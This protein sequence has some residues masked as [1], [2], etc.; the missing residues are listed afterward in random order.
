MRKSTVG[1]V[2]ALASVAFTFGCT[3]GGFKSL[4]TTQVSG[5]VEDGNPKLKVVHKVADAT[6]WLIPA[7]DVAAM[8]K[9]PIEVKRDAKNDEPL[10]DNLAANRA[11]YLK[12]KTSAKGEFNFENVPGGNY[13][14]Y[15]EPATSTY[16][17]GGDKSRKAL[18]NVQLGAKPLTIKL[19]G[20]VPADA[21]YVGTT[22]CLECH[23]DQK[24]FINTQ[25]RL[26]IQVIG[27]PSLLQ[28]YSRFPDYNKGLDKLMAGTKFW[29]HGYDKTRGFDKYQI[30][31]K[32]P[33]DASSVSFTATFF[34]D[35]DG[36]LKFRSENV[37]DASDAPRLYPVELAYGGG[38]YKQRY[39]VRVGANLF[40]F[41]QFNQN[42]SDDFGDRARKPWRDYHADWFFNEETKKLANPPQ[43]K[44]FDKECASCHYNA[45][46][47][48]KTA[49]GDY[50]AGSSN[51]RNGELDID[52]DGKPNEINM[53]CET[54]HGPGSV[55]VAAPKIDMASTIVT[56]S[57]LSAER[58]AMICGQCHS[59]PQGHLKNDQP[60]NAANKM[61]LPGTSRNV[62]LKEYTTREDGAPTDFWADGLHSKSHHQQYSDFIKSPKYRNGTQL[63][64]CSDCHD[65]HGTKGLPHQMRVD[66]SKPEAC[67]SCH[68]N[69]M[70]LK[71]HLADKS[72]CTVAPEKIT[73]TECHS[74]KTAQTGAG[75]G[76]GL[77]G[78]DGKNYWQNDISSHVYDVPRKDNKAVKGI[79]SGKAMPIPYTNQ[80]G[81]A[82][83][84]SSDL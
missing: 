9:T 8:A 61:M 13:F 5:I 83:H 16:L 42:G 24:H 65:P 43:A 3:E 27:K 12:A 36:S 51:D 4:P 84:K 14:V 48:T 66:Q 59:R 55:H 52:G 57:K 21:T 63:V 34:K 17:P 69:S 46:S 35:K 26:G 32:A 64:A 18:S 10:E 6:V 79:E 40:P 81:A 25:H 22:E 33:A 28:D 44:S 47:L 29:F 62:F 23:Q 39:L 76:K 38:V 71:K 7:T 11:S 49:A 67:N 20:N 45:Y 19:S 15:V 56:P 70:D 74:A 82:C 53:G 68:I 54:C 41:V 80:C 72:K 31:T 30:S 37:K 75:F 58:E 78:K 73:C 60:V 1:C 50:K 2:L 77:I